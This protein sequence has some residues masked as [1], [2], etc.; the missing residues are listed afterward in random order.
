MGDPEEYWGDVCFP[1]SC[2]LEMVEVEDILDEIVWHEN[3]LG[4]FLLTN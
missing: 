1:I 2:K 3:T 4:I